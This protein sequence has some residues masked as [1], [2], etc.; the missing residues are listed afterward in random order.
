MNTFFFHRTVHPQWL[1]ALR[2][3]TGAILLLSHLAQFADLG[4]LYGPGALVGHELLVIAAEAPIVLPY[5]PALHSYFY[6]L[7]CVLLCVGAGTRL[8][9]ATLLLQYTSLYTALPQ[10][11]YGFDYFCVSALFYCLVFPTGHYC[12]IDRIVFRLRPS[13][14]VTPSLRVLQLHLCIVYFFAG[15]LKAIGPMW[16]NGDAIWTAYQLPAFSGWGHVDLAWLG[17]YPFFWA[18]LGWAV[19]VVETAYP[20]CMWF[21]RVR[22]YWLLSTI[23]L[24]AG[25]AIFM[26]LYEFSAIMILLNICAFQLPYQPFKRT[27]SPGVSKPAPGFACVARKGDTNS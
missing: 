23:G 22:P 26:G 16:R 9:A 18:V 1:A 14:W 20:L 3:G 2:I 8:A 6:L 13:R 5:Q 17:H 12:G 21:A 27:A 4:H 19:I 25:I 10:L 24:H 7:L 15:W 11:S